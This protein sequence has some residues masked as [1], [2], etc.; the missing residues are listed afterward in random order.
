MIVSSSSASLI[1]PFIKSSLTDGENVNKIKQMEKES[2]HT[3]PFCFQTGY[4]HI[5]YYLCTSL[6]D[7]SGVRVLQLRLFFYYYC[8]LINS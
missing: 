8:L 4:F 6:G 3:K 2:L 5:F 1:P 7:I